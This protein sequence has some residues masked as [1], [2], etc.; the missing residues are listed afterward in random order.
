MLKTRH[1]MNTIAHEAT[2]SQRMDPS[3]FKIIL[4]TIYS[5]RIVKETV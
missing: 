2:D 3:V 1:T 4:R 5:P